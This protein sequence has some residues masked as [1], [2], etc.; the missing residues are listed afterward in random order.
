MIKLLN[1]HFSASNSVAVSGL[2]IAFQVIFKKMVKIT[3][4]TFKYFVST[5]EE[6]LG[7]LTFQNWYYSIKPT[8]LHYHSDAIVV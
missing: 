1:F 8:G 7:E 3:Y 5:C 4:P 6:L 2:G